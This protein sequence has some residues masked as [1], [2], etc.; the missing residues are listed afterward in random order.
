M[1]GLLA[2]AGVAE[3]QRSIPA[4]PSFG[5]YRQVDD[6]RVWTFLQ[7]DSVIG[8]L[9]SR[10]DRA[11]EINGAAG[12]AVF[13][14]LNL[15]FTKVGG[16][17]ALS[18]RGEHF[19]AANG[20][21]L[22][23]ELQLSVGGQEGTIG[24]KRRGGELVGEASR[25]GQ[26]QQVSHALPAGIFAIDN[27]MADQIE[28]Y[29]ALRG[30]TE[31][32]VINDSIFVPRDMLVAP[33]RGQVVGWQWQELYKGVL[34]S[35]F[36][37][38]LE[39]PAPM[40]LFINRALLLRKINIP[41]QDM[42]VYLDVV[43]KEERTGPPPFSIGRLVKLI[44]Q[45]VVFALVGLVGVVLFASRFLRQGTIWLAM[46]VGGVAVVIVALVQVPLQEFLFEKLY[47]PRMQ[48]GVAALWALVAVLPAGIIQEGLKLL[49][50][51]GVE[52]MRRFPAR[53]GMAV[54]AAVG[55][56]LGV[57]EA[58]YIQTVVGETDLFTLAVLQRVLF[59]LFHATAGALIGRAY[60]LGGRVLWLVL[61]A[62]VAGNAVLRLM[63]MFLQ[64]GGADMGL[65]SILSGIL[66]VAFML[67]GVVWQRREV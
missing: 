31:G 2:A 49:G 6:F 45:Y 29:F 16:E 1:V 54:G 66:V 8:T 39:Q 65:L 34:D 57:I 42:R 9:T 13:E 27:H 43:R 17:H 26:E 33:I 61:A 51:S 50:I 14:E 58:G 25:G 30:L 36:L 41:T 12:F 4:R 5:A 56:G 10:V 19:V 53:A 48:D 52:R 20:S 67:W 63:P 62:A 60:E 22:G 11:E 7:K 44:P 46:L 24:V 21:Y 37:V 38:R 47:R 32:Q 15:D 3:A 18:V 59:V 40:E 35:V 28:L 64:T 55:A 23:G